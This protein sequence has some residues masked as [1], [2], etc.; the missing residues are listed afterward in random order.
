MDLFLLL[1]LV[2]VPIASYKWAKKN[3][4]E[5]KV[6]LLGVGF[7]AIAAPFSMGLYATYFIPYVGLIPGII[8]LLLVSFHGAVGFEIATQ[9]GL[10]ASNSVVN[11]TEGIQIDII[12]GF[13]WALVYGGIGYAVDKLRAYKSRPNKAI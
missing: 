5:Y 4:P 6:T 13:F 2:V 11:T 3:K 8:G 7:G 10:R 12:N 9:L 1:F